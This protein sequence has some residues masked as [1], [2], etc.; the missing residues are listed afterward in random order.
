[1]RNFGLVGVLLLAAIV[2]FTAGV[3]TF[4]HEGGCNYI[5]LVNGQPAYRCPG[6]LGIFT[7]GLASATRTLSSGQRKSRRCT[8]CS[9]PTTQRYALPIL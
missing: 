5:L 8:G 6:H 4:H 7:S 1:M 9:I 3:V 2:F